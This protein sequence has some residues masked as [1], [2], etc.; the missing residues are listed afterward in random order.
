MGMIAGRMAVQGDGGYG[1]LGL[2]ALLL[3]A[4][5]AAGERVLR[6]NDG[7]TSV[8]THPRAAKRR[9]FSHRW[10]RAVMSRRKWPTSTSTAAWSPTFWWMAETSTPRWCVAGL[11]W[12][13]RRYDLALVLA[14]DNNGARHA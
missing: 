2:L 8:A 4:A 9:R 6:V 3:T 1:P 11:A 13:P 14:D 12:V 7:D 5:T 10:C